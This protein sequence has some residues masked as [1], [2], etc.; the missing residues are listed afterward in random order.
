[1]SRK[2]KPQVGMSLTIKMV[3]QVAKMNAPRVFCNDT[4]YDLHIRKE[5][6][7]SF[8]VDAVNQETGE[9]EEFQVVKSNRKKFQYLI[10]NNQQL[11]ILVVD[12]KN[13]QQTP[14]A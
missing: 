4:G 11:A 9:L 13:H 3:Q 2:M 8:F 1:M 12:E 10:M 6:D 14:S 5:T 7:A